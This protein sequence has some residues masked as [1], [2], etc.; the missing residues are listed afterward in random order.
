MKNLADKI[1]EKSKDTIYESYSNGILDK[2]IKAPE[3]RKVQNAI[4][5][6]LEKTGVTGRFY[7]D[8]AWEGVK[9][10]NQT[11]ADALGKIKNAEHEYEVSIA[12]DEGGYRKS[13]DGMSQWKQY[14]VEIYVKGADCYERPEIYAEI[15]GS[16][17]GSPEYRN[18][19]PQQPDGRTA[20]ALRSPVPGKRFCTAAVLQNGY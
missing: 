18:Q 6:E 11:I 13:K 20:P 12:P 15:P 9:L 2:S 5:K 7:R 17:P 16:C 19:E 3:K 10:V 14:K 1:L 8:T 4:Y